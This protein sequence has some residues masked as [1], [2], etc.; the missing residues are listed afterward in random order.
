MNWACLRC[1]LLL[2][3]VAV[4]ALEPRDGRAV[5]ALHLYGQKLSF[6]VLREGEKVGTH[7]VLFEQQ[8]EELVVTARTFLSV[9]FLLIPLYRFDYHS[10][11]LWR[12]GRLMALK[13]VTLEN[14]DRSIVAARREGQG[15]NLSG[16]KEPVNGP[17]TLYPTNHWHAGVVGAKE[18]LNTITGDLSAVTIEDMGKEPVPAEDGEVFARRY[19]YSG[20]LEAEVWYDDAGRWVGLRF[21]ADDGSRIVFRCRLCLG[22]HLE[23]ATK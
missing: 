19:V 9:D 5:E 1:G 10:E 21:V 12:D 18:I 11:A 8:G 16:E 6:D 3:A 13:A 15:W 17:E 22:S 20:G 7:E 23:S 14:G 4:L 2:I